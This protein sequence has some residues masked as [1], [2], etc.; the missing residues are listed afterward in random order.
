MTILILCCYDHERILAEETAHW[1][2]LHEQGG[3]TEWAAF[4]LTPGCNEAL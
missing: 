4:Y 3:S 2:G 1:G